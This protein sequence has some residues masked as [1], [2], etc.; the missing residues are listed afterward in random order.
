VVIGECYL[1]VLDNLVQPIVSQCDSC[2]ELR[3]LQDEAPP[4]FALTVHTIFLF[5]WIWHVG[6]TECDSF[7]CG[8]AKEEVYC[9]KPRILDTFATVPLDFL[10]KNVGSV[11]QVTEVCAKCWGPML[12]SDS[13]C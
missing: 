2:E 8:W 6:P 10:M 5:W 3:F 13:R 11:L 9:S 7:L 12:K 4:H 1:N